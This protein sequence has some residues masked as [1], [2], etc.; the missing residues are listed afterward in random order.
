MGFSKPRLVL[1]YNKLAKKSVSDIDDGGSYYGH[2]NL[3]IHIFLIL[4][5]IPNQ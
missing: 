3:C 1:E 5:L 2:A 4:D